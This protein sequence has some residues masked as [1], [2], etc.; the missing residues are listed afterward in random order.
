MVDPPSEQQPE[1]RQDGINHDL[2]NHLSQV[3]FKLALTEEE[4]NVSIIWLFH[5][6]G[7]QWLSGRVLD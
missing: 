5:Y 2:A 7:V 3:A 6:N 4:H 1:K